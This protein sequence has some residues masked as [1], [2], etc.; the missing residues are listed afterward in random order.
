M[1]KRFHTYSKSLIGRGHVE[2]GIPCQDF[3]FATHEQDTYFI[4]VSDGCS[5]A[6]K[7]ELASKLICEELAHIV[8]EKFDSLWARNETDG[9]H[10]INEFVRKTVALYA[11][12]NCLDGNDLLATYLFVAH[13]DGR[14]IS[15]RSGDGG[16]LLYFTDDSVDAL[17]EEKTGFVNQACY[18]NHPSAESMM[19]YQKYED[20]LFGAFIYCDGVREEKANESF[21]VQVDKIVHINALSNRE[22]VEQFILRDCLEEA[23]KQST[24]DCSVAVLSLAASQEEKETTIQ[25]IVEEEKPAPK[26]YGRPILVITNKKLGKLLKK[27]CKKK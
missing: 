26:K 8:C 11:V 16:I 15:C 25:A 18:F 22:K 6:K 21:V 14:T 27:V 17:E 9:K 4:I 24:D 2:E 10:F 5:K 3:S 12:K 7:S 23:R 1:S 13:K 19:D 20:E